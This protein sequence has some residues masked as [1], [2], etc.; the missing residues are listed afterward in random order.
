MCS[1][2]LFVLTSSGAQQLLLLSVLSVRDIELDFGPCITLNSFLLILSEY[3]R[4]ESAENKSCKHILYFNMKRTSNGF[5][6]KRNQQA[7]L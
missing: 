4:L 6:T 5:N 3:Y 1:I 7:E 2:L